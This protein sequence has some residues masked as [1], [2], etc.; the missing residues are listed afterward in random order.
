MSLKEHHSVQQLESRNDGMASHGLVP[1]RCRA[2]KE[3]SPGSPYISSSYLAQVY[4]SDS[5]AVE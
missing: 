5:L 3:M 1:V 2:N 4:A